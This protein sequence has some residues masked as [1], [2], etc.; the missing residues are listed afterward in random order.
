MNKGVLICVGVVLFAVV[1]FYV[2]S[3]SESGAAFDKAILVQPILNITYLNVSNETDPIAVPMFA[4]YYN[5]SQTDA[6]FLKAVPNLLDANVSDDLTI[7]STKNITTTQ[8]IKPVQGAI[9]SNGTTN[10]SVTVN[11]TGCLVFK[12]I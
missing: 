2:N 3:V 8:Y 12:V 4:D 1:A 5:G 11:A 9:I 6:L 7:D 10:W